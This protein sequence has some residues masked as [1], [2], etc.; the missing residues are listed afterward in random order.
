[1]GRRPK[2]N[3]NGDGTTYKASGTRRKP[4]VAVLVVGWTPE[5]R[6]IRRSRFAASEREAKAMLAD[7]RKAHQGGRPLPSD[8]LTVG[9]WLVTWLE[10]VRPTLRFGTAANYEHTIRVRLLPELGTLPLRT[11]A[12]SRVETMLTRMAGLSPHTRAAARDVLK[13]ALADAVRDGYV[14]RNV[15]A[16]SRPPRLGGEQIPAPATSTV[17]ALIAALEAHRLRDLVIVLAATGLR[18]GEAMGLRQE[19]VA[20]DQLTVRYQLQWQDGEPVL[21]EPKSARSRRTIIL[22]P[23]AV[24]ALRAQKARQAAERIAAGRKWQDATGL[25]FTTREGR[26]LSESTVQWVMS[27]ACKAAGIPHVSPHGLRRWA[28][29]VV[30]ATG[31]MKAAQGML[32]HTSAGLTGDFYASATET[33]RKRAADAME[34]ALG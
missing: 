16:L 9:K 25:V 30:A 5:G 33:S 7:M 19:D 12:P 32:G 8:R 31:D 1:M 6:P 2:V 4:W 26:P 29:T 27:E 17:R 13:R 20:G 23:V 28:A 10:H 11:L 24:A 3:A 22:P 14:D 21:T 34:G 15:A 18:V